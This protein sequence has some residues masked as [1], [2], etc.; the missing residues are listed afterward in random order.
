M[1]SDFD[2]LVL[3]RLDGEF[4]GAVADAGDAKADGAG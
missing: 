2:L 3:R 1:E 4:V